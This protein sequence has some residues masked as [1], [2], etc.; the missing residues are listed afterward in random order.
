MHC[1]DIFDSC[2]KGCLDCLEKYIVNY[3]GKTNG[4]GASLLH[5]AA[6]HNKKKY[7]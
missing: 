1:L 3:N 6:L 2:K 7:Y 4:K 5:I